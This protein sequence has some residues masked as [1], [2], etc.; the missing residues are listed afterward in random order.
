MTGKLRRK[1]NREREITKLSI[2]CYVL[3]QY[4]YA[5]VIKLFSFMFRPC[6]S[7]F[8]SHY[9]HTIPCRY[10]S[11]SSVSSSGKRPT[12][13]MAFTFDLFT[14]VCTALSKES[15]CLIL[16]VDLPVS[17]SIHFSTCKSCYKVKLLHYVR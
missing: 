9:C 12:T 15:G 16:P 11:T 8:N 6:T 1:S 17:G 3:I 7:Y 2:P 4:K 14:K 5:E 13:A 10:S